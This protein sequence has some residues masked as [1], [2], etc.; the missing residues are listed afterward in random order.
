[1]Y[2]TA[3]IGKS[4]EQLGLERHVIRN[5]DVITLLDEVGKLI[6]FTTGRQRHNIFRVAVKVLEIN[7]I[8]GVAAVDRQQR[9]HSIIAIDH[10]GIE[11]I[12]RDTLRIITV[13]R[14]CG[15]LRCALRQRN[16]AGLRIARRSDSCGKAD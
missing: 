1:M 6:G 12:R 2:H 3:R 7:T 5:I 15:T 8:V 4:A 13:E 9:I 14:R 16:C 10:P 11:E